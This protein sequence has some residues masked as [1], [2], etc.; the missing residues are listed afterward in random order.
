[1]VWP[2]LIFAGGNYGNLWGQVFNQYQ[3]PLPGIKV[4]LQRKLNNFQLTATTNDYGL[5]EAWGLPP[6]TYLISIKAEEYQSIPTIPTKNIFL[7]PGQ[8]SYL[9]I[10][11]R[12]SGDKSHSELE[13][14][15]LDYTN[16]L[17]QTI[18]TKEQI[19]NYPSGHNVWSL[20]ENQDLSATTNRID[21]GGLW[22][23]MPALF[24]ARGSCSWTQNTYL[25]NGLDV[26]DP[27]WTGIPLFYP[28]YYWLSYTQ[29]I[30]AGHPPYASSPGG[31]FNLMTQE[32][33]PSFQGGSSIFF[34]NKMLQ[35]RNISSTLTKEGITD[36]HGFNHY[37]DGN[38][39]L[40]GPIIKD[41][42]LFFASLSSYHFS[43]DLAD[44][45][46]DDKAVI[47]SGLVSLK[48]NLPKNTL[49]LLWSGQMVR[50]PSFGAGRGIPPSSTLERNEHYYIFQ[51]I[52][53]SRLRDN[54][55]L[56][57]GLSL[58]KGVIDSNFQKGILQ[59]H[60]LEVFRNIPSG[61]APMAGQDKR[62]IVNISAI[63]DTFLTKGKRS[64]YRLV[65]GFK[66]KYSRSLALQKIYNNLHLHF[67]EGQPL[68]IVKYN[69]PLQHQESAYQLDFF[70]QEALSLANLA[71]LIFG[72]HLTYSKGW[73]AASSSSSEN[74]GRISWLNLS[75]RVG[76]VLPV[77]KSKKT[78]FKLWAARYYFT[79][80]L[81]YLT[82]GSPNAL[83]GLVYRW[84]D[85]NKDNKYQ[86]GEEQYLWRRQGPLFSKIDPDLKR[87]Y[88]D[89]LVI[90]FQTTFAQNWHLS[91]SGFIRQTKN[92]V[93]TV[94]I[95]VPFSAYDELKIFDIG[96]DRIPGTHDDLTFTVYNQKSETLGQDFFLL[97]NPEAN[98]RISKYYGLD[99]TLIKKYGSR[100]TFFLS[101]TATSAM[102]TTS[103]GN[104]AWEN[105]DG[106]VGSLYDNPNTLINAQGRLRFDRAYV[107][108]IGF[109]F[110][111]A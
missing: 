31:Y 97:T 92:L 17:E 74:S 107:G 91:L 63:G 50:Q 49:R 60:G 69:T 62:M 41:K 90:S 68:E 104:T 76:F 55:F 44:Y 3:K 48:Y 21:V 13:Q 34:L 80:P 9:K 38:F 8:T 46:Q 86:S 27:Y 95:G 37:V 14:N 75:P 2:A 105:D 51:C 98:S 79:L 24:S 65:Y 99:L 39:H 56:K 77:T 10:V 109:N 18:L 5:F 64:F 29:L 23:S 12:P 20:V 106:V 22:G 42:L 33:T 100:F 87:P 40:S 67:F 16:C 110:L 81:Y 43:R 26:T 89:E 82:Y 93:E 19:F 61:L 4:I 111:A 57:L 32:E 25:L 103:P 1:M 35:S 108:R 84:D 73:T 58:N 36:S 45:T 47:Y 70:S 88:T 96:D 7:G 52:L 54:H 11:L 78:A 66:V 101:L 53:N 72:F 59:P 6:G 85:K 28:D 102:G 94:N 15:S 71:T 30:N 83:G